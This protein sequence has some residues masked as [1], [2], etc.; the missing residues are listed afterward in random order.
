MFNDLAMTF[1]HIGSND[2]ALTNKFLGKGC[3][4]T[5]LGSPRSREKSTERGPRSKDV[6]GECRNSRL[7]D[8]SGKR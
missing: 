1:E 8:L 5:T 6:P 7:K 2:L 4:K 3:N